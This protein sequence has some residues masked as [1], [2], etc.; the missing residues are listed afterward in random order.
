M[1]GQCDWKK[2]C[3]TIIHELRKMNFSSQET[4]K[5]NNEGDEGE[6]IKIIN[7]F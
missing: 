1:Q 3:I 7:F 4:R 2:L 6:G 5:F